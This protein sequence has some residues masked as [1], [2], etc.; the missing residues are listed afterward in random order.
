MHH[1][2]II[3]S[4]KL[5]ETLQD[6]VYPLHPKMNL[7]GRGCGDGDWLRYTSMT[8]FYNDDSFSGSKQQGVSSLAE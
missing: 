7:R 5:E 1:L 2:K 3:L 8:G 4:W 6:A